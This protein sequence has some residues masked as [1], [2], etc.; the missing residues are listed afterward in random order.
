MVASARRQRVVGRFVRSGLYAGVGAAVAAAEKVASASDWAAR[1][2][3]FAPARLRAAT[4]RIEPARSDGGSRVDPVLLLV[5]GAFVAGVVLAKVI[6]WKAGDG[7]R[8][9]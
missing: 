1:G 8:D 3:R 6:S 7:N 4:G 2:R 5:G 9:Q